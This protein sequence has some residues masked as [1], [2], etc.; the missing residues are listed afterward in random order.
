M[1][2]ASKRL[3]S[4][5]CEA[6]STPTTTRVPRAPR[7][8]WTRLLPGRARQHVATGAA[9]RAVAVQLDLRSSILAA[10][11]GDGAEADGYLDEARAIVE[12]FRPP[13]VPYYGVDASATNITVHWCAAPVE[14]Y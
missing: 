5:S 7:S 4:Q 3:E 13:A 6:H 9:D 11:A 1:N 14:H 10:R 8:P 12:E 2:R